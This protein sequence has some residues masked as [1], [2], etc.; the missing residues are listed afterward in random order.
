M[1]FKDG[2]FPVLLLIILLVAAV[3][4]FFGRSRDADP[5][6]PTRSSAP[7]PMRRDRPATTSASIR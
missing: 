2:R 3:Y 4:V 5:R 1:H 7:G 6:E